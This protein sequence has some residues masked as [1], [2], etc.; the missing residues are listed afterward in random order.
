LQSCDKF[1]GMLIKDSEKVTSKLPSF[2]AVS[3]KMWLYGSTNGNVHFGHHPSYLAE[4]RI[5]HG[6]INKFI[7]I[8]A[9]D[10]K[11]YFKE[12]AKKDVTSSDEM[13]NMLR[14][15]TEA[16]VKLCKDKHIVIHHGVLEPCMALYVPAGFIVATASAAQCTSHCSAIK[17]AFLPQAAIDPAS[18]AFDVYKALK[19]TP[20]EVK[21]LEMLMD[22]CTVQLHQQ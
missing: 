1:V 5:Q 7:A 19:P 10:A 11:R 20:V 18:L 15:L 13:S 2:T 16:E 4:L 8:S 14:N 9:P 3:H 6:G 21:T 17:M 22:I 12:V